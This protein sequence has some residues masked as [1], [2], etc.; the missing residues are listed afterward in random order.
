MFSV[1][2]SMIVFALVGAVSPGPVNIIAASTGAQSGYRKTLSHVLGATI[3]YAL[4]VFLCGLSL[5]LVSTLLPE[6]MGIMRLLGGGFLL[7]M[8]FK[9]AT[10][11][12]IGKQDRQ[13]YTPPTFIEGALSQ[14]LNP[15]AWLVAISGISLFVL[16]H[17]PTVLYLF[18]FTAISFIACFAGVSVWAA[19]GDYIGHYLS[20]TR[21]QNVFNITMG[22]LL[23]GSV[24]SM[25]LGL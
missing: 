25:L 15:K 4:I 14:A 13:Y 6:I 23:S 21:R 10:A 7:Y 3:A 8:G 9:I 12:G 1:F 11:T 19:A 17:S 16:N 20:T 5:E 22:T 18:C 24:I 2:S